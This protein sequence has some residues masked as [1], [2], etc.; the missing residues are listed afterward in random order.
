MNN[1]I[2]ESF[3]TAENGQFLNELKTTDLITLS[4]YKR[5]SK[6]QW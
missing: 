3:N 5:K 2:F 4:S 6:E 1:Y